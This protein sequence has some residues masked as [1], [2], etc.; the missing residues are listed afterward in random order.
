MRLFWKLASAAI[1]VGVVFCVAVLITAAVKDT[2]FVSV[3]SQWF[4]G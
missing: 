2:S 1:S 4:G 3:V